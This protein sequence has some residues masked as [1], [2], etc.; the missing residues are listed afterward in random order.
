[1]AEFLYATSHLAG[2]FTNPDNAVGNTPTTWAGQLN[3]NTS[4]TSR[5]A[6]G[7]PVDP[8]TAAA[9]QTIRVVAKK[10]SNSGVPTI[11]LNLYENGSLVQSILAATNVTSTTG[12]TLTGTFNTSAITN[13]NDVEIEVVMSAAGGSPSARNS[14]QISHIEW[15]AETTAAS[16]DKDAQVSWAELE[17]PNAP[18]R[19]LVSWAE[20]EAPTA[21]RRGLVSW[22]EMELTDSPR[23]AQ[24]SWA[25]LEAPNAPGMAV[26]RIGSVVTLTSGANN[27]SNAV[28]VPSDAELIVV[29]VGGFRNVT[30]YFTGG[31]VTLGG[32]ALT[33][34]I[35]GDGNTAETMLAGFY[36]ANPLTGSRTLAWDWVGT[37]V[38]STGVVLHVAFYKGLDTSDPIRWSSADQGGVSLAATA[39]SGDLVAAVG[40]SEDAG[41]TWTNAT[42]AVETLFNNVRVSMAEA[43]PSGD[44]TVS[45]NGSTFP[46]IG[47][48]TIRQAASAPRRGLVSWAELEVPTAPRRGLVSWAELEIPTAPRR[49]LVSWAELETGDSPSDDKKAEVSWAEMEVPNAPRRGLVSWAELEV[50]LSPRRGLVSWAELEVPIAPRRAQVSWAELEMAEAPRGGQL[51]WA[52][53]ELQD[54]PRGAQVSWAELEAPNA[55]RMALVSWAEMEAPTAPRRALVS[56]AELEAP[57]TDARAQISWAEFQVPSTDEEPYAGFHLLQR[58]R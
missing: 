53:M 9:T 11:A 10:G 6:I 58:F 44:V 8:L 51:S 18:R 45:Y 3:T 14:A 46:S 26:E 17:V 33:A 41:H 50:P 49:G 1:M 36:R 25:E 38:A 47:A 7:D 23:E 40:A 20:L 34:A 15:E 56:W 57:P 5:W 2:D 13:R 30:N 35:V 28:T 54:S 19:G 21:P 43:S 27:S 16:T 31:S 22:A 12:Q 39:V 52:E 42:E 32:E 55:P 4:Q 29:L 37:A 48:L 24:V